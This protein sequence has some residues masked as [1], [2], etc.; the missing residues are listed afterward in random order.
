[1]RQQFVEALVHV[2]QPGGTV[3][4]ATDDPAYAHVMRE[5]L[6]RQSALQKIHDGP[7]VPLR[8]R[9]K[10]ERAGERHGRLAIDLM[11]RLQ[12]PSES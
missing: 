4:L 9:T 11:Y 6:G 7:R 8:P 3:H 10:Y 12:A 5:V 1:V 2:L